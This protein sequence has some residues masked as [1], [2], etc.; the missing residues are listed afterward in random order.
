M[1][2]SLFSTLWKIKAL[3][4][5]LLVGILTA[6][7]GITKIAIACLTVVAIFIIVLRLPK[8]VHEFMLCNDLTRMISDIFL[9]GIG[10]L[11][12]GRGKSENIIVAAVLMALI[13]S[14][15]IESWHNQRIQENLSRNKAIP[16]NSN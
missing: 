15:I 6:F 14:F 13:V 10:V 11:I 12:L 5:I 16:V 3:R 2:H 8:F 7:L 4:T 9:T 1:I